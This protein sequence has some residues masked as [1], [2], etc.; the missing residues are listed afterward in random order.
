MMGKGQLAIMTAMA[1]AMDEQQRGP[2]RVLPP[3][4]EARPK[5]DREIKVPGPK[6]ARFDAR[7]EKIRAKQ[8]RT[9]ARR[10]ASLEANKE[11]TA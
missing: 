10:N 5:Y 2:V 8:A 1:A 9:D 3:K 7:I 4:P 11:A 6:R